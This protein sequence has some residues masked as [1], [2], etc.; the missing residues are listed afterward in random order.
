MIHS[1]KAIIMSSLT[2]TEKAKLEKLFG[3]STG[4]VANFNDTTFGHFFAEEVGVDIHSEKYRAGGPSKAKKLRQFWDIESD[5]LVGKALTALIKHIEEKPFSFLQSEPDRETQKQ[6]ERCKEIAARLSSGK[7]N[8]DHLKQTATVFDARHLA[9]QIRR[10]EQSM[11]S[12]PA[13]AIGT[14]KELVETCCKTILAERGK[15]V[16]G[17]PDMPALTKETLRE[18]KLVPEGI[19]GASR[20]SDIL[21]GF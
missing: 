3:M 16:T 1:T 17:T 10:I 9:D 15:P 6:I 13:L 2:Y 14:A 12:D 5:F 19:H 7:V 4:Y 8:L 20:G 11:E 21:N 18:L